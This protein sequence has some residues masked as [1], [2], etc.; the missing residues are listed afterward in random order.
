MVQYWCRRDSGAPLISTIVDQCLFLT[1]R[2]VERDALRWIETARESGRESPKLTAS[3]VF[4]GNVVQLLAV[5]RVVQERIPRFRLLLFGDDGLGIVVP[6][7][8]V[9]VPQS[10]S[11][12]RL[13]RREPH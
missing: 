13:I 9:K 4:F 7:G 12:A 1:R 6:R 2:V 8:A 11:R 5:V 3:A 10:Q